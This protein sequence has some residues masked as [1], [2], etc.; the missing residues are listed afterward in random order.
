MRNSI[1][2]AEAADRLAIYELIGAYAH[3][4]DRR[5][6]NR[7]MSLFTP[8]THFI[9]HMDAKPSQPAMESHRREDVA[10]VFADL[11]KY[12]AD[13]PLPGPEHDCFGQRS[14][15]RRNVVSGSP[16]FCRGWKAINICSLTSPLRCFCQSRW[17]V[18]VW[19]AETYCGLD[20]D[21]ANR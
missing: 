13:D 10:P 16:Y 9:V 20:R 17:T 19:G 12:E 5:D 7:Q 3:C 21:E 2:G 14:S 4:A 8:D 15:H 1:S 11:N 6:A 18:A